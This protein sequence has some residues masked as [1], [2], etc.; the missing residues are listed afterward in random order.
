MQEKVESKITNKEYEEL[1]SKTI[2][3]NNIKEKSIVKGKVIS[4]EKDIIIV[5]VGLKSEGRIPTSEFSRPG[6][7]LEVKI[8]D[9]LE[10]FIENVDNINGETVLSRE[11]AIKQ[12][13]WNHLQDAFSNNKIVKG[14][15]FNKVKGGLSVDLDGVTAF[16]PGSQI[17]TRQII[18]DTKELL[19]KPLDLMILKMDKFRGNI[20]VSRKA[21]SDA[22]FDRLIKELEFITILIQIL[23]VFS[24]ILM[25]WYLNLLIMQIY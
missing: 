21:I 8:G 23:R 14:T 15:P 18:K 20:V 17:D 13:A 7:E 12:N 16:L 9:T 10:V 4:I 1:V 5:D 19:N 22:E 2:D 3:T 25:E 6:Q 24:L 11:K